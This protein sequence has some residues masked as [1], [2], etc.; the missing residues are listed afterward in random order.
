MSTKC[1]NQN[2]SSQAVNLAKQLEAD[3]KKE[4]AARLYRMAGEEAAARY[5]NEE[6]LCYYK[7]AL[8]L[9]S[10]AQ[11]AVRFTLMAAL[12]QI[13]DLLGQPEERERN[14]VNLATLADALDDDQR[15]AEVALYLASFKLAAG[16]FDDAI[17]IARLATRIAEMSEV[18]AAEAG[19]LRL[20]GQALLR[21]GAPDQAQNKLK[22][23]LSLA[24]SIALPL[25]EAHSLRYLG[26]VH[27]ENGRYE[28]AKQ[29]YKLAYALY[30]SQNNLRGQTDLLNNLGKVAYDQGKYNDALEIWEKAMPTYEAMGDQQGRCRL[31]INMGTICMEYGRYAQA[32]AYIKEAQIISQT[33]HLRFGECLTY[34]N[35]GLIYHYQGHHKMAVE[36]GQTALKIAEEMGSN[37]LQGI[38][39]QT[40]GT[41]QLG[42]GQYDE[43]AQ[44]YWQSMAIWMELNNANL[45]AEARTGLVRTALLQDD[46]SAVQSHLPALLQAL[47][48]DTTL[49]GTESP[50]LIFLTAYQA[51]K[52]LKDG[53]ALGILE[54]AY[55]LLQQ[56]AAAISDKETRDSFLQVALHQQLTA[57][58]QGEKGVPH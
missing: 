53:R 11:P 45:S 29:H 35:L 12:E 1:S 48:E 34:V 30:K 25:E 33:I 51:L 19:L 38:A 57:V 55:T 47:K 5:K 32:E 9:S 15:R 21:K 44:A 14:L 23:A 6:A 7:H 26:V 52:A 49:E 24:Q 18:V 36:A 31:L 16:E 58:Y 10:D 56:R 20:W 41:S 27:E 8:S 40:V 46:L 43:A 42:L 54:Q 39:W 2:G 17:S 37:R 50:L 28:Q 13:Y 4:M 3:G 22:K